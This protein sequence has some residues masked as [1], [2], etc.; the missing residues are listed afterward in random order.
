[1][2]AALCLP[3]VGGG[4]AVDDHAH[5]YMRS[6]DALEVMRRGPH[7]LY[8]FMPRSDRFRRVLL[9]EGTMPWYARPDL[10]ASFFRPLSSLTIALDIWIGRH[11]TVRVT[12]LTADGRSARIRCRFDRPLDDARYGWAAWVDGYEPFVPPPPGRTL[13]LPAITKGQMLRLRVP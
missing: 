7:D 10:A 5:R 3:A 4:L 9:E 8:A 12:A 13:V 1:M 6:P 11:L 2:A